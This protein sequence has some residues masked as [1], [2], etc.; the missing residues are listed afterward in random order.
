MQVIQ[1]TELRIN[2]ASGR[3]ADWL[4]PARGAAS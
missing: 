1:R 4:E 2:E 3:I